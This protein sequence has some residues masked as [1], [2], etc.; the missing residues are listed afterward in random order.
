MNPKASEIKP[1]DVPETN[2]SL[3]ELEE[4]RDDEAILAE[5]ESTF[6]E[7]ADLWAGILEAGADASREDHR[8]ICMLRDCCS[9]NERVAELFA[10]S[11][12]YRPEKW[13]GRTRDYVFASLRK[14]EKVQMLS[15]LGPVPDE[16][17]VVTPPK[18][19]KPGAW[20]WETAGDVPEWSPEEEHYIVKRLLYSRSMS[21]IYGPS[22]S[23]KT[24]FVL[25][26][27]A[28]VATGRNW[29]GRKVR[30]SA[31]M[32][33][34]LEGKRGLKKRIQALKKDGRL[35]DD[36]PF[37]RVLCGSKELN[38]LDAGDVKKVV[39]VC[40]SF[41]KE[42]GKKV[43]IIFI[44]TLARSTPGGDENS[45]QDMG[46]AL[47]NAERISTLTGA[48]VCVVHHSGKDITKGMRGST[49][50]YAGLD[51]VFEV[52]RHEDDQAIRVW[53]SRKQRDE[54]DSQQIF[55]RLRVVELGVDADLETV[56]SCVVD[57]VENPFPEGKKKDKKTGG[58]D[59]L[60]SVEEDGTSFDDLMDLTG[61]KKG[62]LIQR[63]KELVEGGFLVKSGDKYL[64]VLADDDDFQI[65][66]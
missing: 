32:Y 60:L 35:R 7:F 1:V 50:I 14:S 8:L 65:I 58:H 26:I 56:T 30:Q 16:E 12:L 9:S 3:I 62:P 48:N 57:Y 66:V 59:I 13:G 42:C 11:G 2:Y 23:G 21:C 25:D 40:R 46:V 34:G 44:D 39:D 37:A 54:E 49:A 19:V 17:G 6:E 24:F 47:V 15:M 52:T 4:N 29:N 22:G 55:A 51:E 64:K 18:E 10:Q 5:C 27:A 31:V 45:S 28:A 20:S 43:G 33:F 36:S 53:A 63:L 41:E 38:L 61:M